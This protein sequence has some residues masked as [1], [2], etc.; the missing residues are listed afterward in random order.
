MLSVSTQI[1]QGDSLLAF[2][3]MLRSVVFADEI[4]IFNMERS[5]KPALALFKKYEARVIDIKTPTVVETIRDSQVRVAHGDWVLVMDYDEVITPAL[6]AEIKAI[7]GNL[8]SCSAYAI[9]RDNFSLGF[10]LKHGGWER[11]HVVRLIRRRD[12]VRWPEDI[13]SSP[14]VKGTT[15][16]TLHAMEHHKDSSLTQMVEKTNR[17]SEIEAQQ[18]YSGGLPRVTALTL[19]RKY[20][21]EYIRRYFL[22]RGFLDGRIGLF[23]SL[24]QGYSVFITYAKLYELQHNLYKP[25]QYKKT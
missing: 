3:T 7:T 22:K 13:H 4:V 23:Q 25:T 19:L 14:V 11:D 10:P 15:I 2:E 16:Q 18:F 5:D 12:F 1:A 17:Y 6:K 20:L 8:A 9:P 24:Y 21:M